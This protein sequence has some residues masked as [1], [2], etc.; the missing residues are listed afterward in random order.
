MADA[1]PL[2][3]TRQKSGAVGC[4]M[5]VRML[6]HLGEIFSGSGSG[7]RDVRQQGDRGANGGEQEMGCMKPHWTQP[8]TKHPSPTHL[9]HVG[10]ESKEIASPKEAEAQ[11]P[12]ETTDYPELLSPPREE[13]LGLRG[14]TPGP[15]YKDAGPQQGP[16]HAG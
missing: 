14:E 16:G 4:T 8:T 3:D 6:Q 2:S 7:W 5:L 11:T 12:Q 1:P 10:R 15:G 9:A 13:G